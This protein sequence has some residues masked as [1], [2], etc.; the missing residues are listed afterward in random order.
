MSTSISLPDLTLIS[1][2]GDEPSP[3]LEDAGLA[4]GPLPTDMEPRTLTAT[5]DADTMPIPHLLP[6]QDQDTNITVQIPSLAPN[7]VTGPTAS[8]R[9]TLP[10]LTVSIPGRSRCLL[11]LQHHL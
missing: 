6:N 4:I 9:H 2:L 7:V 10:L 8:D 3:T 11:V 5:L 1:G